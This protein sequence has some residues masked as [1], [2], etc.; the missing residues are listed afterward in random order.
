M[1]NRVKIN[2]LHTVGYAQELPLS[3][4]KSRH[5]T[6]SKTRKNQDLLRPPL[7]DIMLLSDPNRSQP[8]LLRRREGIEG[9]GLL[10]ALLT[11]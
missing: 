8:A 7:N 2:P 9:H 1:K 6:A 10:A 4:G 3:C 5:R 11:V